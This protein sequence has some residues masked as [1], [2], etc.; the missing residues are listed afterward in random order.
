MSTI[1]HSAPTE[2]IGK[3]MSSD[4]VETV[5]PR[6]KSTIVGTHV[7]NV[8]DLADYSNTR[9]QIDWPV[10]DADFPHGGTQ[11]FAAVSTEHRIACQQWLEHRADVLLI[12]LPQYE[13]E[14]VASAVTANQ[15][16]DLCGGQA[17]LVWLARH[18]VLLAFERFKKIGFIHLGD[19]NQTGCFLLIGQRNKTMSPTKAQKRGRYPIIGTKKFHRLMIGQPG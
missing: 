18:P 3:V 8:E 9:S 12:G 15:H 2:I 10:S 17:S 14:C 13:I 11:R 4:A 6:F 1:N 19:A 16:R 5:H 7:L